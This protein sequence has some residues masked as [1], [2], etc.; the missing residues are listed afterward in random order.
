LLF[1]DLSVDAMDVSGEQQIDVDHHLWK[2]RID[3]QGNKI[4]ETPEKEGTGYNLIRL[5]CDRVS[6]LPLSTIFR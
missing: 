1:S 2:Q 4:D 5:M 6:I 3:L